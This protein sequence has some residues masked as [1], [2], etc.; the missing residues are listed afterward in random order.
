[1]RIVIMFLLLVGCAPPHP[2]VSIPSGLEMDIAIETWAVWED[3]GRST[4]GCDLL[5]LRVFR[6]DAHFHQW[7]GAPAIDADWECSEARCGMACFKFGRRPGTSAIRASRWVP[8]IAIAEMVDEHWINWLLTHE[9]LHYL[10]SCS[11]RRIDGGDPLHNDQ[12]IWGEDGLW[13]EAI[14]RVAVWHTPDGED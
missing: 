12:E 6:H 14:R 7:C 11:E 13:P 10:I 4:E 1:M 5:K 3:S 2:P 8:V 9:V